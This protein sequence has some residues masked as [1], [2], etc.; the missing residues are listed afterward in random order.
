[1]I[2]STLAIVMFTALA[3]ALPAEAQYKTTSGLF[4]ASGDDTAA[5]LRGNA[6]AANSTGVV[7]NNLTTQTSGKIVSIRTGNSEVA[8]FNYAGKLTA[9]GLASSGGSVSLG[10]GTLSLTLSA[11]TA[12][13][14]AGLNF[15]AS[16]IIER[17]T[18]VAPVDCSGAGVSATVTQILDGA[19]FTCAT[20]QTVTLPTAQGASG[21]VQNL[22]GA[23]VGS[24]FRIHLAENH[25]SNTLTLAAGTGGTIYGIATVTNGGRDWICRVTSITANSETYTCY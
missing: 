13:S 2:R 22:P 20:S 9:T 24:I 8:S 6:A 4:A 16:R 7:L 18:S 1:M 3:L 14:G 5:T 23:A 10:V 25:A 17:Q 11:T 21:I 19:I 15:A 12:T